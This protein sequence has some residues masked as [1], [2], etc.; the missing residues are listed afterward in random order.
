MKQKKILITGVSGFLGYNLFQDFRNNFQVV[1]TF[2]GNKLELPGGD[3]CHLD[4]RDEEEVQLLFQNRPPDIIIHTA[5]LTSPAFCRQHRRRARAV[6]IEGAARIARAARQWRCSLIS[7]S[8][9]RVFDGKKGDY[10]EDDRALPRGY[11]GET[12]LESEKL[13][14]G[15]LPEAV[16]LRLPLLY[17]PPSPFHGSFVS[18]MIDAF[19]GR[20][21]L[22]LFTDQFRTP[23]YV[24]DVSRALERIIERADLRGLFHLGGPERISRSDFGYRMAEIFNFD[25]SIIRPIKMEEKP[26]LPPSPADA[27]L[28]SEK[29]YKLLNLRPKNVKEGLRALKKDLEN[30]A[31][32]LN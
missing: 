29:L 30:K 18:W 16:V 3:T 19:R 11:Y 1:G 24:T 7:M 4:I 13:I 6:N 10:R 2:S 8:T 27:S 32:L 26:H 17:G 23:L 20:N 22:H 25:P 21:P 31:W 12:K 15:I 9:D 28:N 14:R 5:A